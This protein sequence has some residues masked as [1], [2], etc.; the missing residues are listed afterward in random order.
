MFGSRVISGLGP[1][2]LTVTGISALV[3]LIN[4]LHGTGELPDW[5]P[6]L[7]LNPLPFSLTSSALSF[8]LVF[9]TNASYGRFDEVNFFK[10]LL[11]LVLHGCC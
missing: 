8:L 2:V 7:H 6:L 5:V 1:P 4:S 11:F 3:V 10:L 9:R